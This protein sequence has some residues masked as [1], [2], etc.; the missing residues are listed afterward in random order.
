TAMVPLGG[1]TGTTN[2]YKNVAFVGYLPAAQPSGYSASAGPIVAVYVGYDDNHSMKTNK[3]SVTGAVGALPAWVS[4][5]QAMHDA[6]ESTGGLEA[7]DGYWPLTHSD[8]IVAKVVTTDVGLPPEE[9]STAPT[10]AILTRADRTAVDAPPPSA[11]IPRQAR[12]QGKAK[13]SR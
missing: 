10:T 8:Q 6:D 1:K 12:R 9:G 5:V 7:V 3:I 13:A 11:S 4:I 2:D